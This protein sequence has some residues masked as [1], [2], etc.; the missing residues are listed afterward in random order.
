LKI[1]QYIATFPAPLLSV[2]RNWL[3]TGWIPQRAAMGS[4][5]ASPPIYGTL[6]QFVAAHSKLSHGEETALVCEFLGERVHFG[7]G[8]QI[9]VRESLRDF[10]KRMTG[11]LVDMAVNRLEDASWGELQELKALGRQQLFEQGVEQ[12]TD[13]LLGVVEAEVGHL[14]LVDLFSRR[15][16]EVGFASWSSYSAEMLLKAQQVGRI[17]AGNVYLDMHRASYWSPAMAIEWVAGVRTQEPWLAVL[18]GMVYRFDL[19][20]VTGSRSLQLLH[21]ADEVSGGDLERA[22]AFLST[23]R[24]AEEILRTG[25]VAF[26]R[27]WERRHGT[28]PGIGLESLAAVCHHLRRR[29][30]RLSSIVLALAPERFA[31]KAAN[32]PLVIAK[33]RLADLYKLRAYVMSIGERLGLKVYATVSEQN[34]ISRPSEIVRHTF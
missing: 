5:G 10:L 7:D 11:W 28:S 16:H 26:L 31:P 13:C 1:E 32:E 33:A 25:D 8:H 15:R 3:H 21:A 34:D 9:V 20:R 29:H 18:S 2:L 4:P 27:E 12:F 23:Y 24:D 22:R 17:P 6:G 19:S 14:R 30:K